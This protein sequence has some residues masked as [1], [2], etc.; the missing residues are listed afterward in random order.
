MSA[1]VEKLTQQNEWIMA[2]NNAILSLL[3]KLTGNPSYDTDDIL[4]MSTDRYRDWLER[5]EEELHANARRLKLLNMPK[6]VYTHEFPTLLEEELHKVWEHYYRKAT[7]DT[8]VNKRGT[9]MRVGM[10]AMWET[11]SEVE[12]V[13]GDKASKNA[14]GGREPMVTESMESTGPILVEGA[15]DCMSKEKE[16]EDIERG[17]EDMSMDMD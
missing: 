6:L 3:D 7:L 12:D 15:E 8:W 1:V 10:E 11:E 9:R 16:V 14:E 5:E 13:D 17:I 4:D 2:Q